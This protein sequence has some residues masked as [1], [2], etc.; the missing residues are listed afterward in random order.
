MS[1]D[2]VIAFIILIAIVIYQFYSRAKFEKAILKEY[3]EKFEEW[4]KFSSVNN[5]KQEECKV[6]CGLVFK[7]GSKVSID[8]YDNSCIENIKRGKFEL[9]YSQKEDT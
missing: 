7:K 9:L 6:F 2:I 4:K 1:L 8:I 3:D 5:Q